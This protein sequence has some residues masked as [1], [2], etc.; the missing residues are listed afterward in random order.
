MRPLIDWVCCSFKNVKKVEEIFDR[1]KLDFQQFIPT[2]GNRK[3]RYSAGLYWNHISCWY[4]QLRSQQEDGFDAYEVCFTFS[5]QGCRVYETLRGESFDWI[6]WFRDI[7]TGFEPGSFNFSRIDLALDV[8]DNTVPDMIKIIH[9]AEA[10]KYVSSFRR[11]VTGHLD[12]EWVY[13]GSPSSDT[14][15]RIYNKAME[16]DYPPG[17]KWVRFEFQHRDESAD[18]LINHMINCVNLGQCFK[19]F[20]SASVRFTK[21]KNDGSY[22]QNNQS[23]L[24]VAPWWSKFI[25][26]AGKIT[27]FDHPGVE[28][29]LLYCQKYIETQVAPT[30]AAYIEAN[31][32][33]IS[34]LMEIV[35][36]NR[37]RMNLKQKNMIE[38]ERLQKLAEF[39]KLKKELFGV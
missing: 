29:N 36:R 35:N 3:N 2:S 4:N 5:G 14:R 23:K 38:N 33:D 9:L 6:N 11:V 20:C 28:Y 32:G 15:L 31:E 16:R 27:K 25:S 8:T 21:R 1:F 30:L 24:E 19:D 34:P 22:S 18:R 13:F 26:G 17:T 39:E 12:E 7:W 10:K 37:Y